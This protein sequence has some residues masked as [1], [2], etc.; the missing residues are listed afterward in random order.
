M[1]SATIRQHLKPLQSLDIV[2][3]SAKNRAQWVKAISPERFGERISSSLLSSAK[4]LAGF[5]S[6]KQREFLDAGAPR[7]RFI[8]PGRAHIPRKLAENLVEASKG[9]K[10]VFGVVTTSI[11]EEGLE[12][13]TFYRIRCQSGNKIHYKPDWG[14]FHA[15]KR[16]IILEGRGPLI[17]FHTHPR[18]GSRPNPKDIEKMKMLRRGYWMISGHGALSLWCFYHEAV[19]RN[20]KYRLHVDTLPLLVES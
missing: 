2:S 12:L 10:V 1:T 7:T 15:A 18:G 17:E 14:E 13:H 11:A 4:G 8:N 6:L 3:T 5:F 9:N 16:K 20:G 19:G